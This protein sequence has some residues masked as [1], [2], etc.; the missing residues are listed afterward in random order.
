MEQNWTDYTNSTH[1]SYSWPCSHQTINVSQY[2]HYTH[3]SPHVYSH[4]CRNG[5]GKWSWTSIH[6]IYLSWHEGILCDRLKIIP[7]NKERALN[8]MKNCD[9]NC[10]RHCWFTISKLSMNTSHCIVG[11][12]IHYITH[13]NV[14]E[15][16]LF[17]KALKIQGTS[18]R[19]RTMLGWLLDSPI[20]SL[21]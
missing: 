16:Y 19:K 14:F 13:V 1:S 18:E 5:H 11:G 15:M 21:P 2:S 9:E 3:Y 17:K 7:I 20:S 12:K 8:L 10:V 6:C 4:H